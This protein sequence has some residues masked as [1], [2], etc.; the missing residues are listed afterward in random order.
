MTDRISAIHGDSREVLKTLAAASVDSVVCDPPYSL[1]SITKRWSGEGPPPREGVY[2]RSTS[3]FMGQKWDTG[4]TAHDPEFWREVYRVLKPGAH[5]VAFGGTRT[6]HRLVCAIE[7]AGFEVRDQIAWIFGSGFPKSHDVSKGIDRAAGAERTIKTGIKPGHE[8]FVGRTDHPLNGGWDRPWASDAEAVDRYH[9]TFAPATDA[10]REW[11]GWGTALKPALE[12]IVL[13]RKPLIGTVA[14]NVLE[15]GT[16]A[17]N[18]D[19]CRVATDDTLNGSRNPSANTG[20]IYG[21]DKG[22]EYRQ[23]TQGRWPANVIHDGSEE[24]VGAFPDAPG[25]GGS[26]CGGE[27]SSL[28]ANVYGARARVPCEN[29]R[30]DTGS[31]ARFFYTAKA[32]SEDRIGSKHPTVKPIDLMQ[33]LIRLVTPRGG[34]VLDPFAGTGTTGEAAWR[35]GMRALL[36]E[37]EATYFADI[38]RR[39]KLLSA[40]PDERARESIKASGKVQDAGPLFGGNAA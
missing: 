6:F 23:S 12:P 35:E 32:D 26:V 7:D 37:R 14:E 5:V 24:V 9:S 21:V 19:G 20:T 16:G 1:T 40:G 39:I 13:A 4:E 3:G 18:V 38:Q 33:Y 27:P 17:I 28:I 31:A 22:G 34:L 10:A 11:Q 29:P 30:S 25:Q 36:I 8:N 15:H 2:R